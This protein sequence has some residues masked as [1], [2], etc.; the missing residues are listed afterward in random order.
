MQKVKL[1][2]QKEKPLLQRHVQAVAKNQMSLMRVI[3]VLAVE[4]TIL[5]ALM[6]KTGFPGGHAV[7]D[8]I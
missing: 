3:I 4:V 7:P 2:A 5:M 6:I 8:F 1:V